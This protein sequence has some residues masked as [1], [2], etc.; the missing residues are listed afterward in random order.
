MQSSSQVY[1]S[2]PGLGP[3]NFQTHAFI[4]NVFILIYALLSNTTRMPKHDSEN[5][6]RVDIIIDAQH[7]RNWQIKEISYK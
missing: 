6:V 3:S 5:L 7:N 2:F 1:Q 4:A